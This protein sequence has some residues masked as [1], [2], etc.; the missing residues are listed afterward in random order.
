LGEENGTTVHN[1]LA[2]SQ[3]HS[4]SVPTEYVEFLACKSISKQPFHKSL[5]KDRQSQS[6]STRVVSACC[7]SMYYLTEQRIIMAFSREEP[8]LERKDKS[9]K[10][11]QPQITEKVDALMP[12][13]PSPFPSTRQVHQS[14]HT[15]QPLIRCCPFWRFSTSSQGL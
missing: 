4:Q 8:M 2:H 7:G 11:T 5:L 9:Q 10:D 13:P 6:P 3:S 12:S 1:S 14:T 15:S